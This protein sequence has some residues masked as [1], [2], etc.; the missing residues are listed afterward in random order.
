VTKAKKAEAHENHERWLVS[1]ADFITLLFAFFVV[2]FASS[3]VNKKKVASIAASFESYIKNG[4][5]RQTANAAVSGGAVGTG[6][7]EP[8]AE[9]VSRPELAAVKASLEK[10][11]SVEIGQRKIVLSLQPRGLVLSL[12]ESALFSPGSDVIDGEAASTLNKIA[13]AL[14]KLSGQPVRL[15][16]HTDNVPIQT[17][18]F[19]SNWELSTARATA[20]LQLL[21]GRFQIAPER[22]AVAGYADF[23]PVASN[24]TG[25]GRAHNRRVDIVV[26]SRSA[27][28]MEPR[29]QSE[30][31]QTN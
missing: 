27:V 23:H 17:Q 3:Q 4:K 20:V 26:L 6:S 15:E 19:P 30:A 21:T 8:S 28:E 11:L 16:G 13:A 9:G 10:E 2:M 12:R 7:G 24:D 29:R 14:R 5:V 22:L 31:L 25:E 1:Y 18:K